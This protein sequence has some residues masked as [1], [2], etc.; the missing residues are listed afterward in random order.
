M[1]ALRCLK[2]P[3]SSTQSNKIHAE[4]RLLYQSVYQSLC[5]HFRHSWIPPQGTWT[6]SPVAVYFR[7]LAEYIDMGALRDTIPQSF[8]WWFSFLLGLTQQQTDQ[9]RAEDPV[10]KIHACSMLPIRPP[11]KANGSSCCSQQWHPRRRVSD[12]LSQL[13]PTRAPHVVQSK[14]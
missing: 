13:C 4:L 3:V 6:S 10:E 2:A 11:Q 1:A 8:Q 12:C 14:A 5:S 7:T 9:M